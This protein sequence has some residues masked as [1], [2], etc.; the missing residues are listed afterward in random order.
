MKSDV[1]ADNAD[2]VLRIMTERVELTIELLHIAISKHGTEPFGLWS[3]CLDIT[4]RLTVP[5][6][7]STATPAETGLL[8][9]M[10]T[11]SAFRLHMAV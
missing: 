9:G 11:D 2:P 6:R 1:R 8:I 3:T 7:R 5:T 4:F 10:E